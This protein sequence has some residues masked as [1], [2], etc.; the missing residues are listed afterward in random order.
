M[1]IPD[2]NLQP[3]YIP[4]D[5]DASTQDATRTSKLIDIL[6]DIYDNITEGDSLWDE[7]GDTGIYVEKTP[8]EDHLRFWTFGTEALVIDINQDIEVMAGAF[9][10]PSDEFIYFDGLDGDYKMKYNSTSE[11]LE[12]WVEGEKRLEL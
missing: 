12:I 10:V 11:Y 8:D 6:R 1:D 5:P 7:D 9:A 2:I 3:I 4:L